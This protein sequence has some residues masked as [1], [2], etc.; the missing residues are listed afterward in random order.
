MTDHQAIERARETLTKMAEHYEA[1]FYV[2]DLRG[3]INHAL[4]NAGTKADHTRAEAIRLIL[5]DNAARTEAL[6]P[7]GLA[8]EVIDNGVSL[9]ICDDA[10]N[11]I[12][13]DADFERARALASTKE[14]DHA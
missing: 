13:D 7:F 6:K 3:D 12:V 8:C 10:G 9:A 4:H 2:A 5:A 11:I 14:P 1:S